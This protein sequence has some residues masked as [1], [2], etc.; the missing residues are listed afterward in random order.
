[1]IVS[2]CASGFSKRFGVNGSPEWDELAMEFFETRAAMQQELEQERPLLTG[3][4]DSV[5][6]GGAQPHAGARLR[7]QTFIVVDC[8]RGLMDMDMHLLDM[9][10]SYDLDRTVVLTKADKLKQRQIDAIVQTTAMTLA[11]FGHLEL[12]SGPEAFS[13]SESDGST[14]GLICTSSKTNL[15]I[16]QLRKAAFD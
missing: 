3:L 14:S 9:L 15:G 1:M 7:L 16:A 4:D 5:A 8:R 10:A 11:S 13:V 2:L 12:P 6:S